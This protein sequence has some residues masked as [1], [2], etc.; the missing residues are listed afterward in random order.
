M[1]ESYRARRAGAERL[2]ERDRARMAATRWP[3]GI[4][5]FSVVLF[6]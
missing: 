5:S 4:S 3:R 6:P 1:G 2:E